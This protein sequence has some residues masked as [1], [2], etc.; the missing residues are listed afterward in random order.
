MNKIYK[1]ILLKLS[2]ISPMFGKVIL[3][4]SLARINKGA[5]NVT[6]SEML[7]LLKNEINPQLSQGSSTLNA[8]LSAGSGY[9]ITDNTD[10][11]IYL[12]PYAEGLLEDAKSR[13]SGLSDFEILYRIGLCVKTEET[14]DIQV[15]EVDFN[16]VTYNVT[17]SPI[18]NEDKVITGV[19]TTYQ[20]IT[21]LNE[22][23]RES[24]EHVSKLQAEIESRIKAEKEL[25]ENQQTMIRS[26]NLAAL[27]E[28][29]AGIAHEINN[30]LS[31]IMMNNKIIEMNL[32]KGKATLEKLGP[33]IERTNKSVANIMSIINTMRNLSRKTD[34]LP[35]TPVSIKDVIDQ[36]IPICNEKFK[37][38]DVDLKINLDNELYNT[39]INCR[40]TEISQVL[41]NLLNNAFDA[42]IDKQEK[43]VKID[44][45]KLDN[46]IIISVIDSGEGI[47][48]EIAKNIFEP[49]YTTKA[50]GSGT[51]LGLSLSKKIL[52]NHNGDL[53]LD[54]GFPHTKFDIVLPIYKE[55]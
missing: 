7:Y 52:N 21:L 18:F 42:V 22:L 37:Y 14:S 34:D 12:N 30:P 19:M 33:V 53:L 17:I 20:D 3:E 32:K 38:N 50:V 26:S 39:I 23:E 44:F 51:G 31:V 24:L 54:Q 41:I 29:G 9:I 16:H 1:S 4:D 25:I 35:F 2:A 43:W 46:N 13:Y 49:F 40:S 36:A 11:V 10:K 15:L 8:L 48:K 55:K 5:D 47:P 28:M 45:A 6:A 27:G